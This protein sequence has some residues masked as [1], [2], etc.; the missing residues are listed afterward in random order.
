[1]DE[2]A[3][4]P[5]LADDDQPG[6]PTELTPAETR[7]CQLRAIGYPAD[8]AAQHSQP[9]ARHMKLSSCH[10]LA[11]AIECRPLVAARLQV[12]LDNLPPDKSGIDSPGRYDR[13]LLDMI[14]AANR[15]ENYTA[16]A[17]LM[18]L[19]DKRLFDKERVVSIEARMSPVELAAAIARAAPDRAA[20]AFKLV[21]KGGF[22][23]PKSLNTA[24]ISVH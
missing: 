11:M 5:L 20:Q 24:T 16:G 12:L 14:H 10:D 4:G 2:E 21:G 7:Y 15:A 1:M 23:A 3:P 22:T 6:E 8:K 17:A 9:G 13:D 18:R 19:R